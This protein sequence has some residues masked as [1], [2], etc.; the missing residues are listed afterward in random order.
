MFLRWGK[1]VENYIQSCVQM[2]PACL[3]A[4]SSYVFDVVQKKPEAMGSSSEAQIV[5]AK[6]ASWPQESLR[7]TH[8][9]GATC[10]GV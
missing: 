9:A 6:L 1:A 10:C 2:K 4:V 3:Q 7:Q 5:C 8:S